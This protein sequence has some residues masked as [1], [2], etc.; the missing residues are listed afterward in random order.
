MKKRIPQAAIFMFSILLLMNVPLAERLHFEAV[1]AP[2]A[3]PLA[4]GPP[5]Q[6]DGDALEEGGSLWLRILVIIV[7]AATAL[8]LGFFIYWKLY[9][10]IKG[11]FA[12]KKGEKP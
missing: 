8:A 3:P 9:P 10:K 11:I 4:I 5:A 6:N 1:E 2:A 12:K 7:A